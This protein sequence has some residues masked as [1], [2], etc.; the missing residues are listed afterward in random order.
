MKCRENTDT[1]SNEIAGYTKSQSMRKP[2]NLKCR[3]S[4]QVNEMDYQTT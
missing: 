3:K 4:L 2:Q 1:I